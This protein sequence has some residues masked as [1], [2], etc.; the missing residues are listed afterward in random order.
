[1]EARPI[2]VRQW[3]AMLALASRCERSLAA[4]AR[5]VAGLR[6][7]VRAPVNALDR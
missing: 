7:L 3:M 6:A 4:T 2:P 5:L 1:M